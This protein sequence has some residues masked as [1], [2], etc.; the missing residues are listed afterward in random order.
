MSLWS[1]NFSGGRN[2]VG[3]TGP[4]EEKGRERETSLVPG[5][6]FPMTQTSRRQEPLVIKKKKQKKTIYLSGVSGLSRGAWA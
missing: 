6:C 1:F 2:E 5:T 4:S 3:A